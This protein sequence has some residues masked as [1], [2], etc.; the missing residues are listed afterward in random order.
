M[1]IGSDDFQKEQ[2]ARDRIA[3]LRTNPG[4]KSRDPLEV[5]LTGAEGG[6]NIPQ[7]ALPN[8]T[9][10]LKP[11]G[12]I[13]QELIGRM[14]DDVVELNYPPQS[15]AASQPKLWQL[16]NKATGETKSFV[17]MPADVKPY[18]DAGWTVRQGNESTARPT[19]V[20]D[21][22]F[23]T[24]FTTILKQTNINP[25]Q[26]T[27]A[28]NAAKTALISATNSTPEVKQW[29]SAFADDAKQ[30]VDAGVPL[31]TYPEALSLAESDI[32]G[33]TEAERNALAS[34]IL[35]ILEQIE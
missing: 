33:I 10:V 34:T 6:V 18:T 25:N 29:L 17:G 11:G 26:R 19:P 20:V 7:G 28:F 13:A 35:L 14:G 4:L 2:D 22:K 21:P 31:R 8:K 9:T 15:T 3:A 32:E 5:L 1:Y 12:S 24:A 16:E 23:V 30:R 27:A